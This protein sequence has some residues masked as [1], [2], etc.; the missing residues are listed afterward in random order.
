MMD[1]WFGE[2]VGNSNRQNTMVMV[3][4]ARRPNNI[5]PDL[6]AVRTGIAMGLRALH[7][8]VLHEAIPERMSELLRLLGQQPE[9]GYNNV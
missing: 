1:D 8:D 3:G 9:D 4:M 5:S 2:N 7:S 6:E